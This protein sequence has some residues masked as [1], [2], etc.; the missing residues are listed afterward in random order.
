[1]NIGERIKYRRI[2]LGMSQEELAC[3]LGYKSRSSINKIEHD[4]SGLPQTKIKAIAAALDTTPGYI[5]GWEEEKKEKPIEDDGLS[6]N[7]REL[8][9]FVKSVPEEKAVMIQ[10]V[11][12][13]ILE[14]FKDSS[15]NNRSSGR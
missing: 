6:E 1:M 2:E 3:K 15:S 11:I 7:V 10:K 8:V 13:S 14:D 5:M 12:Q 4:A 9:E